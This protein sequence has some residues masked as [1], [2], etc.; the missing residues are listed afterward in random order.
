[1]GVYGRTDRQTDGQRPSYRDANYQYSYADF[2]GKMAKIQDFDAHGV[3]LSWI[4]QNV[5]TK[6]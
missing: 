3:L 4:A 6:C 1:M 5:S 2:Q